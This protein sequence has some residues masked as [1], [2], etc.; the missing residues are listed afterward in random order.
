M[1]DSMKIVGRRQGMKGSVE[2][3]DGF[4]K[5]VLSMR[6][7]KPFIPKGVHRF[8]SFEESDRWLIRM[9]TRPTNQDR[10]P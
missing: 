9:L 10:Q 5:M 1:S 3:C 7:G 8:K 6:G 2:S 4:Q